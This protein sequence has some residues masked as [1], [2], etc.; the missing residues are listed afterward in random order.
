M[1]KPV[2]I[3]DTREQEGFSFDPELADVE[4]RALPAGD[5]SLAGLERRVAVERKSLDDFVST[6]IRGR[7]RFAKELQKLQTYDFACV[8]I[9]AT[10]A[11][12]LRGSYQSG[13][14]PNSVFGA[15][16]SIIVDCGIP[17]YFCSDRQVACRF[18]QDI[19][20]R[21]HRNHLKT[22]EAEGSP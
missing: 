3:I 18:T 5:Y 7:A 2:I 17:A 1:N 8:V 21:L 9:E 22:E 16:I 4:R 20:L 13:A 11:E 19:L 14:H 10:L 15:V 12:V 6:V